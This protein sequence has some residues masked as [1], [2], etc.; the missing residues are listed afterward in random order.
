MAKSNNTSQLR[1]GAQRLDD[2][3][4]TSSYPLYNITKTVGIDVEGK[5]AN[6]SNDLERQGSTTAIYASK[7]GRIGSRSE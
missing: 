6:D 7:G 3:D 4:G 2:H 1:S 5:N